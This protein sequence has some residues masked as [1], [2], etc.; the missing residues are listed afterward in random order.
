MA[1]RAGRPLS[2]CLSLTRALS[3]ARALAEIY[4]VALDTLTEA[5][6]LTRAAVLLF[7][8]DG[9]MRFKASRGL[10]DAYRRAV[11][12]HTPWSPETPDPD[13]IVVADVICETALDQFLPTIVE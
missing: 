10:S 5:L 11:E 8:P 13:P 3:Q 6:G 2:V 1:P 4:R 7:D 12:G 9:V